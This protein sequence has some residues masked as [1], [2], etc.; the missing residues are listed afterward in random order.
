M[1]TEKP[2]DTE[3]VR[4]HLQA[5]SEFYA[6]GLPR[7]VNLAALLSLVV[8]RWWNYVLTEVAVIL[9]VERGGE[10]LAALDELQRVFPWENY[11]RLSVECGHTMNELVAD[12]V[13]KS[14][15]RATGPS[16]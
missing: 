15:E 14:I 2:D 6:R 9:A 16:S 3:A 8:L 7:D 10:L 12:M 5:L 13:K 4:A 11:G 1:G